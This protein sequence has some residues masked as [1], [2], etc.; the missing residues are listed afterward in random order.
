M[1]TALVFSSV[2]FASWNSQ[3]QTSVWRKSLWWET[4][5]FEFSS[6]D[7]CGK[8]LKR[9]PL[10]KTSLMNLKRLKIWKKLISISF[11]NLNISQTFSHWFR[12]SQHYSYLRVASSPSKVTHYCKSNMLPV[13]RIFWF[14]FHW[15][16][17]SNI[18]NSRMCVWPYFRVTLLFKKLAC[19]A[20]NHLFKVI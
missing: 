11:T 4:A 17:L 7:V 14:A 20:K 13:T 12:G 9:D 2:R 5:C 1:Y 15:F 19:W 6:V 3:I 16:S 18:G 10:W 8:I